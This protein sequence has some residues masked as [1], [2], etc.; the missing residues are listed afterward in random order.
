[1]LYVNVMK[2]ELLLYR[3]IEKKI[4]QIFVWHQSDWIRGWRDIFLTFPSNLVFE[5]ISVW[6]DI[7]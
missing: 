4:C 5:Q 3:V 2:F 6:T 7:F 1:M